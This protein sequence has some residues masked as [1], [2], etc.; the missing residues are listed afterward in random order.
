M[1]DVPA[2][3]PHAVRYAERSSARN[4]IEKILVVVDLKATVHPCIEKAVRLA[5]AFSSAIELSHVKS[6]MLCPELRRARGQAPGLLRLGSRPR[7]RTRFRGRAFS[8]LIASAPAACG[9]GSPQWL[10]Y[11]R[12]PYAAGGGPEGLR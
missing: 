6:T 3:H 9:L 4:A 5:S 10:A 12:E 1:Y 11:H 2:L 8:R 7:E